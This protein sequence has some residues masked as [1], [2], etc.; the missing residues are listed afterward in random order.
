MTNKQNNF[1]FLKTG[2]FEGTS[3]DLYS[4]IVRYCQTIDKP[5][6]KEK[7]DSKNGIILYTCKDIMCPY[8][9]KARRQSN[10]AP[11]SV[12]QDSLHQAHLCGLTF[13]N[14]NAPR[15]PVLSMT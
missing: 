12:T 10:T 14:R 6:L 13:G 2:K 11:W 4:E 8:Q 5:L 15:H 7:N 1:I 9:V 3:H